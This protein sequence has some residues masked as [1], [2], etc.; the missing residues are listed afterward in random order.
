[1]RTKPFLFAST[2]AIILCVGSTPAKAQF[3]GGGS[4]IGVGGPSGF[5]TVANGPMLAPGPIVAPMAPYSYVAAAP[6]VIVRPAPMVPMMRPV[7]YGVY[8]PGWGPRPYG[9]YGPRAYGYG[10]RGW[11]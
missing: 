6:G 9:V 7:P 4:Y 1:M 10:R 8:R 5:M 3:Y 11:W 2:L